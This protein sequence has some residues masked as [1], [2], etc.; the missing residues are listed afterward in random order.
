[1]VDA[2][3]NLHPN[4]YLFSTCNYLKL[5]EPLKNVQNTLL[6]KEI[7]HRAVSHF[8][9]NDHKN[10]EE[11]RKKYKERLECRVEKKTFLAGR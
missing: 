9:K 11:C 3:I 7:K 10:T 8:V 5:A 4:V 1:M 2:G 6:S